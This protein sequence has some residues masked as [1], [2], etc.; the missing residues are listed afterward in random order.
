LQPT[1][2]ILVRTDMMS[3]NMGKAMAQAAHAANAF[4]EHHQHREVHGFN[5][6][7]GRTVAPG[8]GHSNAP[9]DYETLVQSKGAGTTITLAVRSEA[10]LMEVVR[11]ARE[12]GFAAAAYRDPT[13]PLR[14][15]SAVHHFPVITTGYVFTRCRVDYK[16]GALAGLELHP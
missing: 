5:V 15:G 9:E 11:G 8:Y 2:Y 14:D 7:A 12:E 1:L 4:V 13:Y 10:E 6:W 3:M 16:V